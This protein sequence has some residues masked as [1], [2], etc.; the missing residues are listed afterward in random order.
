MDMNFLLAI[1]G[2]LWLGWLFI[3]THLKTHIRGHK[4]TKKIRKGG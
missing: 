2:A 4:R 3:K 1:F